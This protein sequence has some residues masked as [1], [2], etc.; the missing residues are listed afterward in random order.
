MFKIIQSASL[1]GSQSI[2]I[3]VEVSATT[4]LPQETIIG[5]PDTV[6]KESRSR[7]KSAILL[8]NYAFPA[9]AY[10]INL[11]PTDV[12][13]KNSSLELAIATAILT[14][15]NQ[16]DLPPDLCFIGGLSLDGTI[17]PIKHLLPIIYYLP[18]YTDATF[19]IAADN[20]ADIAPLNGVNYIG[21][22]HLSDLSNLKKRTVSTIVAK[23]F[24]T[25]PIKRSFDDVRGH[26]M[27]K[28]ACLAAAV[29][30][31]PL[32][33]IGS[34]GIGKT[35]LIDRMP[36]LLPPLPHE[37]ALQNYCLELVVNPTTPYHN[38]PPYRTP[39]HSVSYAG[40]I[41][42]KNPPQPG[43]ITRANHGILF[44]D[45][46]GEYH[47]SI[48]ETLREPMETQCI[49]LSRAGNAI[50]YPAN[51]LLVAAMNPC[52]CGNYYADTIP[53][54]CSTGQLQKYWQKLSQPFLDRIS[55]CVV[56]SPVEPDAPTLSQRDLHDM[57]TTARNMAQKRNPDGAPNHHMSTDFIE[58]VSHLSPETQGVL[59]AYFDKHQSSMRVKKR[60]Y[61]LARTIAD[62]LN[63]SAI[64]TE[65]VSIACQLNQHHLLPYTPQAPR[66]ANVSFL[67]T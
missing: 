42:G 43:E 34:P 62:T 59:N 18:H 22:R 39:H 44:L 56:L 38:T 23:P 3:Q 32:L 47:R 49:H 60:L 46:I 28:W 54:R 57:A 37:Q 19:V 30:W 45:E 29:G 11:A 13:K 36:T 14:I 8:S 27:A 16:I 40:M 10:I 20:E 17:T 67:G 12:P 58:S 52:Y 61:Q 55:I 21:I 1:S 48:L 64:T 65:A 24:V 51:F 63:Q 50:T 33:F 2:P 6:I 9:M 41:G 53:C 5:L 35:L 66:V 4:G 31:H 7:I 26:Y 15:T 25:T